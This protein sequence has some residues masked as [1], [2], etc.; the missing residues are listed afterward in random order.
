MCVHARVCV[1]ACG[2]VCAYVRVCMCVCVH[3]CMCVCMCVCGVN[4]TVSMIASYFDIATTIYGKS[5]EHNINDRQKLS[6]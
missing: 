6:A 3:V 4:S 2:C 5:I 1:Y